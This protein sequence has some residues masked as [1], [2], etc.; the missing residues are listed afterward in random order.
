MARKPVFDRPI[1]HRGLHDRV[2]GI[3][4][5]SA[6]AFERAIEGGFAIECDLQLTSDGSAVVFHDDDRERLTG[7]SGFVRD[8]SLRDM[9]TTPLLGST[10]GDCPQTF[11][12]FLK[13]AAGRTLLQVELKQQ[14]HDNTPR[15]AEVAANAVKNY[16]GPLVFESFDPHLIA[17]VRRAGFNGHVGIIT[18]N[19]D[20][21]DWHPTMTSTQRFQLR[22]LIHAPWS[23]FDFISCHQKALDLP[24]VR[25]FR[26]MGAPVTA[27]TIRS[28]SEAR[29]V[30]SRADQLVF[31]GFDPD[32]A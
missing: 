7:K 24:A 18:Y 3:I 23:R 14:T 21:P 6:S 30:G 13:Q 28:S 4:E 20:E 17:A 29:T 27:W 11:E 15:L 2:A 5:N 32:R 12:D 1:A 22:H 31:E 19:Y 16:N 25:F 9:T 8:A 10:A 26:A